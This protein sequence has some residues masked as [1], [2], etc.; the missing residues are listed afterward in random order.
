[1]AS[2]VTSKAP[3]T[4]T[5]TKSPATSAKGSVKDSDQLQKETP[6]TKTPRK[7]KR[8][9]DD[10]VTPAAEKTANPDLPP[11]SST[12]KPA[13]R[14]EEREPEPE[15]ESEHGEDEQQGAGIELEDNDGGQ[16]EEDDNNEQE[17]EEKKTSTLTKEQRNQPDAPS[18]ASGSGSGTG[19]F[20]KR[21]GGGLT[22]FA[23][24]LRG[25][26]GGA[27]KSVTNNIPLDLS[28]V[29]G[30]QV[31]DGG[32][33][34]DKSGNPL[35]EVVEGDPSD[36]VGQT[37]GDDG[38]ILDED[39][40]FIGRVDLLKETQEKAGETLDQVKDQLPTLQDL[41]G[42]PVSDG[43]DI[44]D[45]AG[46]VVARVVEGDAEDLVGQT[47]NDSGEIVDEDGDLIGRVEVISPEDALQTVQEQVSTDAKKKQTEIAANIKRLRNCLSSQTSTV[48]LSL[49]AAKS[50]TKPATSSQ[51]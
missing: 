27:L 36:L 45:K 47:L 13:K 33:V 48:Y 25:A 30:S 26:A 12:E 2:Q 5:K 32:K 43:G 1:M 46:N 35:A 49:T 41:E 38:E 31:G 3:S 15:A 23:R 39:G 20:F 28:A 4:P 7:L 6:K 10:T 42:L 50:K 14:L 37:V 34:L 8:K 21:T 17:E 16:E 51:K 44:K 24:G 11:A 40:D 22:D 9:V 29:K 19:G 18:E